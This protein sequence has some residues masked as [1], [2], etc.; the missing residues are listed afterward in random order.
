MQPREYSMDSN[1]EI[2]EVLDGFD[3]PILFL[4]FNRLDTSKLILESIRKVRPLKLYVACDGSRGDR[5]GE[6]EKVEAVREYVLKSI[7]WDCEVKTLFRKENLGCG[8]AVS[9][10]ITWFFE[11]E[12]KGIILEDDCLPSASFFTYCKELLWKYKNEPKIF[13]IAGNNPLT[14]TKTKYSYYFARIEHCWGWA[15]WRRAW[16]KYTLDINDL[17]DFIS[18]KKIS[19]IFTR[20]IDKDYWVKIFREVEKHEIDSW[21]YSWTYAI[22]NNDGICINP[23][24]NLI[25]NIGFGAE[26]THT[27]DCNSVFHN[28]QRFEIEEIIHH[29]KIVINK[30]IINQ[31]NKVAFNLYL[32][33]FLKKRIKRILKSILRLGRV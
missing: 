21:A 25:T 16:E 10:A 9:G 2:L 13:H 30:R 3:V 7:D 29:E 15:T 23:A 12:E 32:F 27:I 22:F 4:I 14:C 31:I 24:K 6:R 26:A 11:N 18:Q 20:N 1:H 19:K 8:K 17:D 33:S 5:E 28:Q